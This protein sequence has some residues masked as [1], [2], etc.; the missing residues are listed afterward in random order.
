M[1][2]LDAGRCVCDPLYTGDDCSQGNE[3]QIKCSKKTIHYIIYIPYLQWYARWIAD[4][5]VFVLKEYVVV[6]MGGP[7]HCVTNDHAIFA[8]MNMVNARTVLVFAHKVGIVNIVHCVSIVT[9]KIYES[10]V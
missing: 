4:L 1:Y 6:M 9:I 3:T 10:Y 2:D 5:T 8:V 7:V